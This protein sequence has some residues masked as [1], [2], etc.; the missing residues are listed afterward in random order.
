[1]KQFIIIFLYIILAAAAF[2]QTNLSP[3]GNR[4]N[5]LLKESKSA[6][7]YINLYASLG[8]LLP[9]GVFKSY[10]NPGA[11][12]SVSVAY[13]THFA[14]KT[15]IGILTGLDFSYNSIKSK[16][17]PLL[18]QAD[19]LSTSNNHIMMLVLNAGGILSAHISPRIHI[20]VDA[21]VGFNL[22][23]G[24]N[25]LMYLSDDAKGSKTGFSMLAE[26]GVMIH[27][28]IKAKRNKFIFKNGL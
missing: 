14:S 20:E 17:A 19:T 9:T 24:N 6:N 28:M 15:F 25:A 2:S 26:S 27:Y 10:F 16:S 22:S 8:T 21:K 18:T 11:G 13:K 7:R 4:S 5:F 1:M 23:I 3:D 12:V